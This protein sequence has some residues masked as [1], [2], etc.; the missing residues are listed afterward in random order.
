MSMKK[1]IGKTLCLQVLA[2]ALLCAAALSCA[3]EDKNIQIANQESMI[4]KYIQNLG[5][6]YQVVRNSGS[7]RV[8]VTP[9]TGTETL[10]KGDSLYYYYSGYIFVSS[11]KGTIFVTNRAEDAAKFN[12]EPLPGLGPAKIKFGEESMVSGLSNG[13]V[14][15]KAGEN[16]NIIFSAQYGYYDSVVGV[17]PSL[18]PLFYDIIIERIIK[19]RE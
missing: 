1:N 11:G 8:I 17:V 6:K 2:G 18:S 10:E 14:G 15:V 7:N 4:D 13:L 12:I 19:N 16:C 9:G 5:D 3:K